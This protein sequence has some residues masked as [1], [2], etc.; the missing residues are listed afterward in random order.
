LSYGRIPAHYRAAFSAAFN[1]PKSGRLF[2]RTEART[3][4]TFTRGPLDRR[5]DH[6]DFQ[7]L[8][9]LLR[10]S[11]ASLCFDTL[12]PGMRRFPHSFVTLRWFDAF[13]T[14]CAVVGKRPVTPEADRL[15]P[16]RDSTLE[17]P[18]DPHLAVEMLEALFDDTARLERIRLRNHYEA[19]AHHDWRLR[20]R[21]IFEDL[22]LA[23]PS[24]LRGE[25]DQLAERA[26]GARQKAIA[27]G[28]L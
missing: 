25:L 6:A 3:P 18:D 9:R 5:A 8:Y 4:V 7:L 22:S 26:E 1:E 21:G 20:A 15:M 16:W 23:L 28:A 24:G 2:L 10:S 11:K 17:L 13:A 19:L 27:V 14:G 12:Y